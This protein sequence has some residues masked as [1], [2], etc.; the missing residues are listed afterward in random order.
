MPQKSKFGQKY[1]VEM[2]HYSVHT[3]F[4]AALFSGFVLL[5]GGCGGNSTPTE[6]TDST[7]TDST[8]VVKV[9]P[10]EFPVNK[11]PDNYFGKKPTASVDK[12][13]KITSGNL[14]QSS[15]PLPEW[16]D[17]ILSRESIVVFAQGVLV[18]L[19]DDVEFV[20]TQSIHYDATDGWKA[21][22]VNFDCRPSNGP[23]NAAIVIYGAFQSEEK[24]YWASAYAK[25]KLTMDLKSVKPT[26]NGVEVM[27]EWTHQPKPIAFRANLTKE[28]T[29]IA[30]AQ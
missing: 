28:A 10:Q 12:S 25:G 6:G 14:S 27:G 3:L 13:I 21:F 7:K 24:C 29:A 15:T 9:E 30:Q 19:P 8:T 2:K 26:D 4:V 1:I 20:Q 23:A 17:Q 18:E 16:L 5:L 22:C 11:L